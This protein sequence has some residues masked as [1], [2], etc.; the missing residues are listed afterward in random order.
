MHV[1][2]AGKM[3]GVPLN[4][5]PA[6]HEAAALL[7]AKGHTVW[8]P[9]EHDEELGM[10]AANADIVTVFARDLAAVLA[11]DAIVLIPGWRESHGANLE[12]HAAEVTRRR[13]FELVDG[14]LY[15]LEP[16]DWRLNGQYGRPRS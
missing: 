2:L 13:V 9:A 16:V 8:S 1:Y 14:D 11:S 4:N 12:R 15:E 10:D 5:A 6:F 7:R 3:R